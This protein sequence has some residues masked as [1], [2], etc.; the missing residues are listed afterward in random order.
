M[1]QELRHAFRLLAKNPGFTAIAALSLA[2]GIG[3]NSAI[4]SL[5]DA[6][7][8]RP[9][10]VRNPSEIVNIT[11]D[12][13]SRPLS[14]VSYPDYRDL[15]DRSRSF[16][17]LV[18]YQLST[19]GFASSATATPQMRLGALVSDNFFQVLGVQPAL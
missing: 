14:R 9:L 15:R 13:P 11:S 1:L 6:I 10:P 7:L 8:L 17:G 19:F 12:T 3:A 16:S 18:A 4:F 2:L 5:V